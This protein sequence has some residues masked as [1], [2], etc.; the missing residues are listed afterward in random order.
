MREYGS[1]HKVVSRA[2]GQYSSRGKN[3]C[4]G[5]IYVRCTGMAKTFRPGRVAVK[6]LE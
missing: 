3:I 4:G 6:A 2:T 5:S 1:R